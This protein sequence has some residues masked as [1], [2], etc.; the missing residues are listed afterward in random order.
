M[1]PEE[2]EIRE[3]FLEKQW[4]KM[5]EAL[6]KLNFIR[7][8]RFGS[9]VSI[10]TLHV[11]NICFQV[12]HYPMELKNGKYPDNQ[13]VGVTH[14]NVSIPLKHPEDLIEFISDF[15]NFSFI[16]FSKNFSPYFWGELLTEEQKQYVN[17]YRNRKL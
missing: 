6:Y 16:D 5:S 9:N 10:Y 15:C 3:T 4:V 12:E 11:E 7:E 17:E 1:T 8:N 2:F 13:Y 14:E